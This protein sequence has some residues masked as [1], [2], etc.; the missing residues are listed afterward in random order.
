MC[1][2]EPAARR[3]PRSPSAS[4]RSG[5][6]ALILP[7]GCSSSPTSVE[8]EHHAPSR[9]GSCALPAPRPWQCAAS[10]PPRRAPT[11]PRAIAVVVATWAARYS[12]LPVLPLAVAQS[13]PGY[14]TPSVVA[15]TSARL[16]APIALAWLGAGAGAV[17]ASRG[18][19]APFIAIEGRARPRG[20]RW[21]A[22]L[23]LE[24]VGERAIALGAG[25]ATWSRQTLSPGVV[26]TWGS[27]E[28][29]AELGAGALLGAA[30]LQGSGFA[31]NRN[32]TSFDAGVTPWARAR[33]AGR[34]A[35]HALGG[36]GRAGWFR[37]EAVAV[38]N[39]ATNQTLPRL[40]VMAGGGFA[41]VFDP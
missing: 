24:L 15:Q 13:P 28:A 16:P 25:T 14:Q 36:R 37:P 40:D 2:A 18:G 22:R 35:G 30:G 26:R 19:A 7:R 1:A 32:A 5:R 4:V 9:S 31:R 10:P 23:E 21:A 11:P 34:G 20:S 8:R 33:A 39:T 29:F 17:L 12:P 3:R 27:P 6:R 41:W 38:G